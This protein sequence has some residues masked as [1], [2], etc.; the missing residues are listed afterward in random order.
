MLISSM[1]RTS[2]RALSFV[3]AFLVF[4]FIFI[5]SI[6]NTTLNEALDQAFINLGPIFLFLLLALIFITVYC[7]LKQIEFA[8]EQNQRQVW[9][10]AAL[11][12]A[13]SISTLALTC[14][15]L[16]IS[17][18]IG[19]LAEEQLTPETV[20]LVVKNL[21]KHFSLAFM[22][23]VVGLPCSALLRSIVQITEAKFEAKNKYATEPQRERD[24]EIPT[25]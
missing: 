3:L 18:G 21:T 19:T 24:Y 2:S 23:T 17:L 20:Q 5:K 4:C 10:E 8:D 14:T 11:Q 12:S 15:L 22:T 6:F 7:W 1:I 16:G 9:T 25:I 13:D